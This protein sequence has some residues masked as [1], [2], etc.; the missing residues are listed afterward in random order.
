[1]DDLN[2]RLENTKNP[3]QSPRLKCL[4]VCSAG[5]LRSS[6]TAWV[7]GQPPYNCNTRNCGVAKE[8]ALI[9]IDRVLVEWADVI[10]V[11]DEEH[12]PRVRHL[13]AKCSNPSKKVY[14]LNI[15][16]NYAAFSR[17]LVDAIKERLNAHGFVG[18]KDE[19]LI[20]QFDLTG[21][22]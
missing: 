17:P 9:V 19:L 18:T 14:C 12:L 6:T 4:V 8:Y 3:W 1:M 7:L 22:I 16:D 20:G 2:G 13:V 11:A 5:I 10:V 15:P 21:T